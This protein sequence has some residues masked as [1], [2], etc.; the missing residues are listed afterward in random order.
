MKVWVNGCFDVLHYGH[1]RLLRHASRL[2]DRLVVG[3]D[4]SRRVSISKGFNRPYHTEK[5]RRFNLLSIEGID[6]V[7]IFDTDD[8]LRWHIRNEEPDVM[9]IGSDYRGK[10]IIGSEF[11]PKIEFFDRINKYSTTNLLKDE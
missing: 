8:E 4:S 2:G 5:E 1:F 10:E 11:I 3:I 9:V 7:V 6:K